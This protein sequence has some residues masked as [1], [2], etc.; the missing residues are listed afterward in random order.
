MAQSVSSSSLYMAGML[1]ITL[2]I[3]RNRNSKWAVSEEEMPGS[4]YPDFL[5]GWCYI[6]TPAAISRLLQTFEVERPALF[7]ID[8]VWVT[9]F[10][11]P[12][13]GIKLVSLNLYFTVYSSQLSCCLRSANYSCPFLAGPTDS[14]PA[15][16]KELALHNYRCTTSR[17]CVRGPKKNF[18]QER[19]PLFLAGQPHVDVFYE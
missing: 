14:S 4:H 17:E 7:W 3:L 12:M 19:N 18:C 2:P 13:A 5:S 1:Q 15:L 10:L 11:G 9:G 16:I 8:D 6:T